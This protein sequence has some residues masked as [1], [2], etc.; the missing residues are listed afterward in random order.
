MQSETK[1]LLTKQLK[2]LD[3]NPDVLSVISTS[4]EKLANLASDII[5]KTK[6]DFAE[7]VNEVVEKA[8]SENEVDLDVVPL[9]N[10]QMNKVLMVVGKKGA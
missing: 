8:S 4:E 7:T 10:P 6:V 1:E 3:E 2:E 9:F 5:P